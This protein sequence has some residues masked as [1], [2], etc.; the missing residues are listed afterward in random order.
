MDNTIIIFTSDNGAEVINTI[1]EDDT[2]S[3]YGNNGQFTG[4]FS[5]RSHDTPQTGKCST[6]EGGMRVPGF[7]SWNNRQ[8][9]FE[10]GTILKTSNL[11]M[12]RKGVLSSTV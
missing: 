6:W 11:M 2:Y 4:T 3:Y 7:I 5:M 10:K 9:L 12:S 1:L 8:D